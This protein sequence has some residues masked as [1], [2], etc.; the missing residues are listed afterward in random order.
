VVTYKKKK[1]KTHERRLLRFFS[2][3]RLL[4]LFGL[5]LR[6][7]LGS[8]FLF[9][10][11]AAA[12]DRHALGGMRL[13]SPRATTHEEK[14]RA[15]KSCASRRSWSWSLLDVLCSGLFVLVDL[16]SLADPTGGCGMCGLGSGRPK[17]SSLGGDQQRWWSPTHTHGLL[18][19]S[20]SPRSKQIKNISSAAPMSTRFQSLTQSPQNSV[21]AR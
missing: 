8:G 9:F 18:A 4:V 11:S 20:A 1:E 7:L 2:C 10:A 16:S 5:F 14:R 3:R 15:K 13:S 21:R 12:G 17:G 19:H 6:T